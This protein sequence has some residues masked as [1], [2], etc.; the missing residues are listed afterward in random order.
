MARGMIHDLVL[1]GPG[2]VMVDGRGK[3]SRTGTPEPAVRGQIG[4][5]SKADLDLG[6][7]SGKV[8]QAVVRLPREVE[9]TDAHR[10][11]VEGV[12]AHL[13]GVW[14]ITDVRPNRGETRLFVARPGVGPTS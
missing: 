10:I 12:S 3:V 6:T 1:L 5:P 14:A 13:D 11:Q 7:A 4:P 9:V 8:V 2:E